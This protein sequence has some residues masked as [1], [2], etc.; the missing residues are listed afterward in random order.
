[1][2]DLHERAAKKLGWS[3][4]DVRSLSMKSLRDLVRPVDLDLAREMD[5]VI[6]SGAYIRGEPLKIRGRRSHSE[7]RG[8]RPSTRAKTV[9]AHQLRRGHIVLHRGSRVT[10][11]EHPTDEGPFVVV[12][13]ERGDGSCG[14]FR[15]YPSTNVEVLES[16]SPAKARA[17]A[18]KAPLKI[19]RRDDWKAP[20]SLEPIK[21]SWK[22]VRPYVRDDEVE[23]WLEIYR[24]DHP[25]VEFV[26]S[27]TRPRGKKGPKV[28]RGPGSEY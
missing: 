5:Y 25:G 16:G 4:R 26:A 13:F 9:R 23:E 21:Y 3:V 10:V 14:E 27:P 18:E 1:M 6:Q 22:L 28:I 24:R 11:T 2:S 19:W 17:H 7:K 15:E 8:P 12:R 20:G